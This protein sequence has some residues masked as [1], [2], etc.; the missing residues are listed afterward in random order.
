ML[1]QDGFTCVA[2]LSCPDE[3]QTKVETCMAWSP[4]LNLGTPQCT[5]NLFFNRGCFFV[6]FVFLATHNGNGTYGLIDYVY[7]LLSAV[8]G[9][10]S[11]FSDVFY[12]SFF[13]GVSVPF[14]PS[15]GSALLWVALPT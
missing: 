1:G 3:E 11:F 2:A 6:W 4:W 7:V 12:C 14:T 9:P 5:G 10:F 8:V 13:F 15:S